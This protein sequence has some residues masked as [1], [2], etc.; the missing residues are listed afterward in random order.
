MQDHEYWLRLADEEFAAVQNELSSVT[1]VWRVVCFLS[2]SATE[3]YLKAFLA[4]RGIM[5]PRTH[6]LFELLNKAISFDPSLDFIWIDCNRLEFFGVE[7][8]Y[9]RRNAV[10]DESSGELAATAA[11]NIRTA[12]VD[13]IPD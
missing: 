6:D 2:H 13:R 7:A 3:K 4:S 1:K 5:P 10:Y 11:S 9:P 8:R 12:I